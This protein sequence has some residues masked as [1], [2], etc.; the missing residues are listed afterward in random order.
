LRSV[1]W[2]NRSYN[3]IVESRGHVIPIPASTDVPSG[4]ELGCAGG[5]FLETLRS[6]GWTVTGI[7]PSAAAAG[8]AREKGLDVRVGTLESEALPEA[9]FDAVFAW[10]VFEHVHD[11][12]NALQQ[13]LR[14]LKP[15]GTFVFSVPNFGCWEAA[16]AGRYWWAL[17]VPRHLQHFTPRILRRVLHDAGFEGVEIVHQRNAFNLVGTFGLWLIAHFPRRSWGRRLI[18]YIDNPRA[19]GILILAPLAWFF[20]AIRQGGRL[21]VIARKPATDP[22]SEPQR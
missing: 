11:P 13:V 17:D 7:E 20:A 19:G 2:I 14:L 22:S 16:V 4:L 3:W 8:R 21:T 10:M 9:E 6:G 15:A 18:Q 1:G 12:A 5:A